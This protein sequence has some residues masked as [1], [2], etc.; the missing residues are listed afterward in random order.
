MVN[1]TVPKAARAGENVTGVA[2]IGKAG[3]T[4]RAIHALYILNICYI[5]MV[6]KI[7][8]IDCSQHYNN[9]LY[10]MYSYLV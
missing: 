7:M 1:L 8:N 10:F 6:I 3:V 9:I 5:F 4:A 2:I